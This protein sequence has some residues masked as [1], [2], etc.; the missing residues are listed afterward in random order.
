M[1][2]AFK[3]TA[4]VIGRDW[5]R[6]Q[7]L[8]TRARETQEQALLR[9]ILRNRATRFGHAHG[10]ERIR[11]L[12]DY[13]SRVAIADY[14]Q[15]RP[16][17]ERGQHGEPNV[18]TAE[19]VVMFTLTS[20]STGKPKLIPV[21]P[22]AKQNH[23]FLTRLWYYHA[24][25]SHAALFRGKWLGVVSPAVEGHTPG[26]I[27]FGAASGL[28]YQSSPRSIQSAYV[29]PPEVAEIKDF[30][31]KYYVTMRLAL[32]NEISFLGTPNPSTI[33]KLV[34]TAD[35]HRADLIK[36]IHDG[37]ISDRC[38]LPTPIRQLLASRLEKKPA[39]ARRLEA[40]AS[41]AGA[42]KPRDYWPGLQLIG[43][44]KGGSVG[45]RLQEFTRWFADA[46]PVRD[47]G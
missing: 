19:P 41:Q 3:A 18:L 22:T 1:R 7:R 4:L 11:S 13:C 34:E 33:L 25:R 31:A 26:G 17:V 10:F 42:L 30:E 43:C 21:T 2:I 44:W 8:T 14:E 45:V 27:P 16:Y 28:V 24:Y 37:R 36:D 38:F 35:R 15:L 29:N 40:C 47:L 39:H 46:T 5:K 6:W 9:I 20:G 12:S 23:R 32:E